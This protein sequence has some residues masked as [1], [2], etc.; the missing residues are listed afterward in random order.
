MCIIMSLKEPMNMCLW[1]LQFQ[2]DAM[3]LEKHTAEVMQERGGRH[4]KRPPG[5]SVTVT[6]HACRSHA[7]ARDIY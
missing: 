6:R 1:L 2:K 3:K 4:I 7:S 5:L